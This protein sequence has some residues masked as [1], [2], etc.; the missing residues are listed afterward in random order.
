MTLEIIHWMI[1]EID[2]N[3]LTKIFK[4]FILKLKI[5]MLNHFIIYKMHQ[6]ET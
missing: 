5:K 1:L 3:D 4:T 2:N 6:D